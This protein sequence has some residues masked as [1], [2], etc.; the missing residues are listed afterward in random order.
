M[1]L[2]PFSV[3]KMQIR[4]DKNLWFLPKLC[5]QDPLVKC[6]SFLMLMMFSEARIQWPHGSFKSNFIR[7]VPME[8]YIFSKPILST[9]SHVV[10]L[11]ADLS[12]KKKKKK[13]VLGMKLFLGKGTLLCYTQNETLVS[14]ACGIF[15][16]LQNT[17]TR[18]QFKFNALFLQLT[19]ASTFFS[20]E[21]SLQV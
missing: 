7:H 2:T 16:V 20:E 4:P 10:E 15:P 14:F 19:V 8:C 13:K 6:L 12:L 5:L 9:S 18:W 21:W 3:C 17:N 11:R 1:L